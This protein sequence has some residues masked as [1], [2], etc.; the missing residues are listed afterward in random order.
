MAYKSRKRYSN[1]SLR[2]AMWDYGWN[3][4]Y[5]VTINTH[6]R[7]RFFGKVIKDP[8]DVV[9]VQL[10]PVGEIANDSWQRI[11]THFPFAKLGEYIVMPDHVHGIVII[12]KRT[13]SDPD[14][15][16]PGSIIEANK[17]PED[18]ALIGGVTGNKNPML[19]D[20][21]S[22]AIRWFKGRTSYE[23]RKVCPNFGWQS[24]FHDQVIRD[25]D[26]YASISNYIRNNPRKWWDKMNG[27]E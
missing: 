26:A 3:A 12:D 5:F 6:N 17:T 22:R 20:N 7:I 18:A 25:A 13:E 24:K 1:L 8:D 16:A 19:W 10:T 23:A 11:P 4:A 27:N 21:L 15:G 9:T 14:G 2:W